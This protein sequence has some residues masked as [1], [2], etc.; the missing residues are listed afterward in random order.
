M[1]SIDPTEYRQRRPNLH[2]FR[3]V[4]RHWLVLL[5][6]AFICGAVVFG[7]A[8]QRP[9]L[10]QAD[11]SLIFRF[12]REYLPSNAAINSWQGEP[13]RVAID[14]AIHTE[15]EILGSRRVLA[16]TLKSF[17]GEQDLAEEIG[18]AKYSADRLS[19]KRVE[20]TYLVK[21]AYQ[22]AERGMTEAF[23][24]VLLGNYLTA[25]AN[26]LANDP[27]QTLRE[28]EIAAAADL[29]R[30]REESSKTAVGPAK[31]D[32]VALGEASETLA[33]A[34]LSTD[35]ALSEERYRYIAQL[36]GEYQLAAQIERGQ[37]PVIE[38][39]DP[40]QVAQDPLGMP[41]LAQAV[42][43]AFAALMALSAAIFAWGWLKIVMAPQKQAEDFLQYFSKTRLG[44]AQP[45]LRVKESEKV[46]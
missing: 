10:H 17:P 15:M 28:A 45:G 20:G 22:H 35:L 1:Q 14:E 25:R 2:A 6:G 7:L 30:L 31:G 9:V 41:P 46:T 11:S 26:L 43:A 18:L 23:V 21:V 40:P 12:G 37:G 5:T 32:R 34:L 4:M 42:L 33:Q 8:A 36:R 24:N 19:V 44:G 16:A 13:V 29:A 38:V 39:L 27:S 3:G